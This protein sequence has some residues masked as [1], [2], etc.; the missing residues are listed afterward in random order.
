MDEKGRV[1][2]LRYRIIRKRSLKFCLFLLSSALIV[3]SLRHSDKCFHR[4]HK[5]L[6]THCQKL[7]N[8]HTYLSLSYVSSFWYSALVFKIFIARGSPLLAIAD[9]LYLI[10]L[11]H[12]YI[13]YSLLSW[14]VE[15]LRL[16][17]GEL[18]IPGN[19]SEI[20]I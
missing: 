2:C 4:V 17:R 13:S 16:I 20:T 12:I 9:S 6:N 14:W 7:D 11:C 10:C 8:E 18:S 5:V 15:L 1:C 19:I 3:E